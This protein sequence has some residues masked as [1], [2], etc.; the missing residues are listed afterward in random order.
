MLNSENFDSLGIKNDRMVYLRRVGTGQAGDVV[1][2]VHKTT[3]GILISLTGNLQ[4]NVPWHEI[5]DLNA[6]KEK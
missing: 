2:F 6:I 3:N 5:V 1:H 4:Q